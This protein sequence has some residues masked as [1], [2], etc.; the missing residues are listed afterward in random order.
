LHERCNSD[1][2]H[3]RKRY[4]AADVVKGAIL[5][6]RLIVFGNGLGRAIDNSFFSLETALGKAWES[7][8][9]S[10]EKK[11]AL[12]RWAML[13]A[14]GAPSTEERF[15]RIFVVMREAAKLQEES[16]VSMIDLTEDDIRSFCHEAACH[17]HY[18]KYPEFDTG[19]INDS[20]TEFT[21]ALRRHLDE[22]STSIATLNYDKLLYGTM[23]DANFDDGFRKKVAPVFYPATLKK[24]TDQEAPLY[25]HLHG[26]PLFLTKKKGGID[27]IVKHKTISTTKISGSSQSHLILNN[28]YFKQADIENSDLLKSYWN[29][30]RTLVAKAERI[31]LFG[32]SGCDDHLN[33]T[34]NLLGKGQVT[35]VVEYE[36]AKY[37]P[38]DPETEISQSAYWDLIIPGSKVIPLPNIL[39]F[40]DW[41][42]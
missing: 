15:G 25:L 32:Y 37:H 30:Y 9:L 31:F 10:P 1:C 28:S 39:D 6:K 23:V 13:G 40:R 22:R 7:S 26:S 19:G 36:S 18:Y 35:R 2:K 34:I 24:A 4:H 12:L 27:Q 41:G 42:Q 3:T 5:T 16:R 29:A 20:V 17:F 8:I 11:K 38:A 33:A 21:S 14:Q